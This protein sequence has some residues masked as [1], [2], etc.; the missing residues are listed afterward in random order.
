MECWVMWAQRVIAHRQRR[1]RNRHCSGRRSR[2]SH[3]KFS[4]GNR[5]FVIGKGA[6]WLL[7][8]HLKEKGYYG[9]HHYPS[10]LRPKQN[11]RDI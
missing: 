2:C 11:H 3:S 5:L 8:R 7:P 1:G 9:P 6:G 4:N 10:N